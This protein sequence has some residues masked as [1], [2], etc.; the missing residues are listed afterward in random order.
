MSALKMV[1][2]EQVAFDI[3]GGAGCRYDSEYP[4]AM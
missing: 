2:G 3:E 4:D 1:F